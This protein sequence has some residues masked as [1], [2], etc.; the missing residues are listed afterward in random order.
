MGNWPPDSYSSFAAELTIWSRASTAK[1]HVMNSI[2]GRSRV[3]AGVGKLHRLL[4]LR[5]H[6]RIERVEPRLIQRTLFLEL[7]RQLG[8]GI[9]LLLFLDLVLG[10]I[11]SVQRVGHRV[12]H[13]AVRAHL[14]QR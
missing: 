11:H 2:T 14:Q 1:F 5:A 7:E 9:P 10:A 13:V 3:G 6:L 4:H 12:S 8:D